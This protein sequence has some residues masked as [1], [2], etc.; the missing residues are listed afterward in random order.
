MFA[1]PGASC[2]SGQRSSAKDARPNLAHERQPLPVGTAG[3]EP[4]EDRVDVFVLATDAGEQQLGR[5]P[6][7]VAAHP[8]VARRGRQS[9]RSASP[10]REESPGPPPPPRPVG[11]RSLPMEGARAARRGRNIG[12]VP[13]ATGPAARRVSTHRWPGAPPAAEPGQ[14][15]PPLPLQHASRLGPTLH[16]GSRRIPHHPCEHIKRPPGAP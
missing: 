8:S 3:R 13:R 1:T 9:R 10:A 5:R 4:G 11:S 15:V 2:S 12:V 16:V 6:V 14:L 7:S